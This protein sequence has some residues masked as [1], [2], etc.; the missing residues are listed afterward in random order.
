M[1]DTCR[2]AVQE[3]FAGETGVLDTGQVVDRIY[4]RY[5]ERPW[6]PN[7]IA[8]HLIGL[9]VNHTSSVHHPTLR[10]HGCLFS[11]GNG[12]YRRWNPEQDWDVGR[13]RRARPTCRLEC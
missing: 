8:A 11:L 2:E 3:V 5:P 12:R 4:T 9:S 6:K 7:A 10:K 1:A 13:H